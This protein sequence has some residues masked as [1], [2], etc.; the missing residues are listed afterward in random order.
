[1]HLR[2]RLDPNLG[3]GAARGEVLLMTVLLAHVIFELTV[4]NDLGQTI[5]LIFERGNI[6][7]T[8]FGRWAGLIP[9]LPAKAVLLAGLAAALSLVM[10]LR[11]LLI[12]LFGAGSRRLGPEE[13]DR[14]GVALFPLMA[15]AYAGL[16]VPGFFMLPELLRRFAGLLGGGGWSD[17]P[18]FQSSDYP[19]STVL[20][21]RLAVLAFGWLCTVFALRRTLA[22]PELRRR[23][24]AEWLYALLMAL[25]LAALYALPAARGDAC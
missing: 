1:M 11:A 14:F 7:W 13:S 24:R 2:P 6:L 5:L 10:G 21:I 9:V 25:I 4:N 3:G 18:L 12:G 20:A 16:H 19:A 23:Y 8:P 17:I 15:A 22:R